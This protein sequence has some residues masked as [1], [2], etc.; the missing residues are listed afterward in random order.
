MINSF[1]LLY[2]D[3]SKQLLHMQL[4]FSISEILHFNSLKILSKIKYIKIQDFWIR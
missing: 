4:N 3:Y 1:N 2:F